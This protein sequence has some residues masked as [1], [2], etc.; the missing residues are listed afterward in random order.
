MLSYLALIKDV[1]ENGNSRSDRT[2][3]GTRSVFGRQLR[4]NLEHGFPLVTTKKLH[5]KSIVHELI[6]FL[7]GS[8]NIQ[9]LKENGVKIWDEWAVA[10]DTG[11]TKRGDLG[12]IYGEQWRNWSHEGSNETTE[13]TLGKRLDLVTIGKPIFELSSNKLDFLCRVL[14]NRIEGDDQTETNSY[15]H[16]LLTSWGVPGGEKKKV[17][18]DQISTLITNLK[19]NPY[20][21]RHIVSAWNVPYLPDESQTPQENVLSG[22]MA[23]A[24]CHTLFQFYVEDIPFNKIKGYITDAE[25]LASFVTQ[26]SLVWAE[27]GPSEE[28]TSDTTGNNYNVYPAGFIERM[29]SWCDKNEIRTK[30]L[31]CQLYARSQDLCLGT[32]Y[33]IASYSL[34]IMMVAQVTNMVAGDYIHTIGDAH[35]YKNHIEKAEEQ[36]T[37]T[38]LALPAVILN[39]AVMDIF[40]FKLSDFTLVDYVSHPKIDYAI[41]I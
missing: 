30:R 15:L 31:S 23:L 14:A 1:L 27:C 9:Y 20:S 8:I 16:A 6:W 36:I 25:K 34:L 24:A 41:A 38:P 29:V 33:N 39:P 35:V 22:K 4:F 32:P 5:L 21:R 18:Y 11:K 19:T 37:R 40:D 3:T 12:P 7:A 17:V 13:L 28:L 26:S 2:N 10:E